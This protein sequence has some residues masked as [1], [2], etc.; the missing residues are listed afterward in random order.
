MKT[1]EV[2]IIETLQTR[3]EIK[4]NSLEEA[5]EKANDTYYE[6]ENEDYILTADNSNVSAE[7]VGVE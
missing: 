2:D 5:V 6:A 4:A 7:F 3:V 1:F